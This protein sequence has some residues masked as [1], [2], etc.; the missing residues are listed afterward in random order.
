MNTETLKK[1]EFG[2]K[3]SKGSLDSKDDSGNKAEE[4]QRDQANILPSL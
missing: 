3:S 4:K 1:R 2:K